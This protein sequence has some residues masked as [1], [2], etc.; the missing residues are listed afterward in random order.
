MPSLSILIP[1]RSDRAERA[2]NCAWVV[3]RLEALVPDSEI[4]FGGS[5]DGPFNPSAAVNDAASRATGE[6]F[7]IHDAD[8]V[9]PAAWYERARE[10]T[11]WTIPAGSV[12]LTPTSTERLCALPP[13]IEKKLDLPYGHEVEFSVG[14]VV[15]LPRETFIDVGGKDERFTG[16]GPEDTAFALALWTL[17]GTPH[18]LAPPML[19]LWHPTAGDHRPW[20]AGTDRLL[21]RYKSASDNPDKMRKVLSR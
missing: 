6:M 20:P 10:G 11:G 9:L 1:W 4:I 3:S 15:V 13:N 5:P 14:G 16:W 19:H 7:C 8:A 2:R 17:V 21:R 12:Y 18:K